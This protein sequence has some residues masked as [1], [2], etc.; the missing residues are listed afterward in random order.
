MNGDGKTR[1]PTIIA[2]V[3]YLAVAR[4]SDVQ[5]EPDIAFVPGIQPGA[6]DRHHVTGLMSQIQGRQ[7]CYRQAQHARHQP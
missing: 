2:Q 7:T 3:A 5:I 4:R 6:P 1:K